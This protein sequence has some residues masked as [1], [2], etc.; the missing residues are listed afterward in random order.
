MRLRG[1]WDF[2]GLLVEFNKSEF[3][4]LKLYKNLRNYFIWEDYKS[5]IY[6]HFFLKEK[7]SSLL[8]H[9]SILKKQRAP[10]GSTSL[11]AKLA[12]VSCSEKSS[13]QQLFFFLGFGGIKFSYHIFQDT[14]F[15][16]FWPVWD[17]LCSWSDKEKSF[18]PFLGCWLVLLFV[19]FESFFSFFFFFC[20]C[21]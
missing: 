6:H 2:S 8:S 11:N 14:H 21:S 16:E 20:V 18:S 5:K 15:Q 7:Q 10:T 19:L 17:M 1:T 12:T 9:Q 3:W 4:K 13:E